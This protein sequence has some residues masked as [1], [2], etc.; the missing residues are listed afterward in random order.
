MAIMSTDKN[1]VAVGLASTRLTFVYRAA[2]YLRLVG[3]G[4]IA[5]CSLTTSLCGFQV[6]YASG[7]SPLALAQ[8][9][10]AVAAMHASNK[11]RFQE[12]PAFYQRCAEP[13]ELTL[14]LLQAD[15]ASKPTTE[16]WCG[17]VETWRELNGL[18]VDIK[19]DQRKTGV[20]LH[21]TLPDG[22]AFQANN[23]RV[24][25]TVFTPLSPKTTESAKEQVVSSQCHWIYGSI[26]NKT[27]TKQKTS[28]QVAHGAVGQ[29]VS[30][31]SDNSPALFA[32]IR[33]LRYA[34]SLTISVLDRPAAEVA[35]HAAKALGWS[36]KGVELLGKAGIA[37][38]RFHGLQPPQ[39]I[40]HLIADASGCDCDVDF[41]APSEVV[42]SK[43]PGRAEMVS[44][45]RAISGASTPA[46]AASLRE[47]M[48]LAD[49]PKYRRFDRSDLW[50]AQAQWILQED[51]DVADSQLVLPRA[52][53][54]DD[55]ILLA[56][57]RSDR[58]NLALYV[59]GNAANDQQ[60]FNGGIIPLDIRHTLIDLHLARNDIRLAKTLLDETEAALIALHGPDP[61]PMA[62]FRVQQARILSALGELD[63]AGAILFALYNDDSIADADGARIA[64][65]MQLSNKA[66]A[67]SAEPT[68]AATHNL[69]DRASHYL[70]TQRLIQDII[71]VS[72]SKLRDSYFL[73][74]NLLQKIA[75]HAVREQ[76]QKLL[77]LAVVQE[78]A[79]LQREITTV[80]ARLDSITNLNH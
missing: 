42:F 28:P 71:A 17:S 16:Q 24:D 44:L 1:R 41:P 35:N 9:A 29:V 18:L 32:C 11:K 66:I 55:S 25:E 31:R 4:L 78:N 79:K 53:L 26:P 69:S 38:Y 39:S 22:T 3:T 40:F 49:N 19:A 62:K 8:Q 14:E 2:R 15:G 65:A 23:L 48:L 7:K 10:D 27:K 51:D 57:K 64:F 61:E 30:Q 77:S 76:Q 60:R 80:I 43:K 75:L 70:R 45:R 72:H 68:S 54:L 20:D 47:Q 63:Q 59:A 58:V 50:L 33:R 56:K 21:I 67:L 13:L 6:A 36:V 12:R 34:N 46:E 73:N 37:S 5:V 52:S 74:L